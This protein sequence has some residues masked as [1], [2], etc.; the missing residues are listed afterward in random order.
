MYRRIILS[1]V[2]P[3]CLLIILFSLIAETAVQALNVSGPITTDTTWTAVNSP[4]VISNK[5][6]IE[7]VDNAVEIDEA[8]LMLV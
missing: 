7:A 4:Y 6:E 5:I 8:I 3:F 2:L 1:F